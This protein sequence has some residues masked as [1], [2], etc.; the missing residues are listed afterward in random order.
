M[1]VALEKASVV[2]YS[3][4]EDVFSA[5]R[6]KKMFVQ[7]LRQNS[8]RISCQMLPGN[9]NPYRAD[10]EGSKNLCFSSSNCGF[11]ELCAALSL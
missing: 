10:V 11:P 4:P 8:C 5:E 2:G 9:R 7:N 6:G 1:S 3:G